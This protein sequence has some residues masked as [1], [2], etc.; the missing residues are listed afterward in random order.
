MN[1]F[2]KLLS[3]GILVQ[4]LTIISTLIFSRLFS[5]DQ[6]G[7]LA[8][9]V[10]FGSLIA[11]V[12]GLRF[13][14]L[15][16]K[17][18]ISEKLAGYF[19]SNII[20]ILM[21]LLIMLI[22]Y[23]FQSKFDFLSD[24][25]IFI[26]FIFGLGFSLFNNLSQYLISKKNYKL[27]TRLR[28]IQVIGVFFIALF[29]K[30]LFNSSNSMVYAYSLSQLCLGMGGMLFIVKTYN[31]SIKN[32]HP[33]VFLK[34]NFH[35]SFQNFTISFMQYSTP[36]MPVLI[37]GYIFDQKNIGAYFVFSQMISAPLNIFRRNL[38]IFFN[39]EFASK[40][41]FNDVIKAKIL[42]QR[43]LLLFTF[44]LTF[45]STILY[46]LKNEVVAI[47]L[48]TQW[49]PYSYLL[50]PLF[51]YFL[52]DCILQPFTTLLPLWGNANYSLTMEFF[53]FFLLIIILPLST[54]YLKI[55]F[56]EFLMAYI[57]IMLTI[58]YIVVFK[59]LQLSK[60]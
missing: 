48:G 5:V 2:I 51:I 59:T 8:F 57:I 6:F 27:F 17:E 60:V 49:L 3:N 21:N 34:K 44:S 30:F 50:L 28:L 54:I 7:S 47:L 42:T 31:K 15:I 52:F 36:L 20:S 37:G 12:G 32:E 38:L 39:G 43:N 10:S 23:I 13:D 11:V 22:A 19:I 56:F 18:N 16:L 24:V 53:R 9:Y 35:E 14:Y 33:H 45:I 29:M 46:F 40:Q 1:L 55:E 41:K 26:L 58:Y 4:F 25:N